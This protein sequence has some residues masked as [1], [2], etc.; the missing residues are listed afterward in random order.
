VK[1]VNE[2]RTRPYQI[3][4]VE[5]NPA[6]MRLIREAFRETR[7]PKTLHVVEDGVHAM[8]FLRRDT[9]YEQSPRPD[10][11]LLDL[12]LPRKSGSEVLAE[13][14]LLDNLSMIPV[15]V[16]STSSSQ[17]DI[18]EAY[19]HRANCFV[20]KPSDLD[21]YFETIHSIE[22]FWLQTVRLPELDEDFTIK[23]PE[24]ASSER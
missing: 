4:V 6:D 2:T 24:P 14:R 22:K 9:G 10:L 8:A 18:Q 7:A 19:R 11:I 21:D 3:L 5:D 17:D 16:F 23:T 12:N 1:T 15:V 13:M 20:S